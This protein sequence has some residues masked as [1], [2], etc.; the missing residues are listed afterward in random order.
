MDLDGY[1][2]VSSLVMPGEQFETTGCAEFALQCRSKFERE[3]LRCAV[4]TQD[5]ARSC[6]LGK[7]EIYFHAVVDAK[8]FD[9]S[10]VA[11]ATASLLPPI[12]ILRLLTKPPK[13]QVQAWLDDTAPIESCYVRPLD[14]DLHA[15]TLPATAR[16]IALPVAADGF[17]IV[18][19]YKS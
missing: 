14:F 12:Q 3:E 11:A 2:R 18:Q 4:R 5:L 6:S 19:L 10:S 16:A 13:A 7:P 1:F 8:M 9:K 15:S 17:D